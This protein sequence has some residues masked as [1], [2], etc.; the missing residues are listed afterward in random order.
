LVVFSSKV[1]REKKKSGD[2]S[3]N[4]I[5]GCG[6]P[7][8]C[9]QPAVA[10]G[11]I[12]ADLRGELSTHL[13]PQ[14]LFTQSSPVC[15]PLLQAFPFPSPLG[16]VTLHPLSQPCVFIHSSHGKWVFPPLLW[17]FLP[18]ATFTSF[19]TSGCWAC[20]AA[21]PAFSSPA[22]C[23]GFPL[24]HLQCSGR[25][26]LFATCLFCCYC[27]LFRFF[28]P[29]PLGGG[30]SVQGAMLIWPRVVCG[31]TVYRFAHLVVRVF[32]SHLGATVWR[33][34]GSPPGFSI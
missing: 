33:Q 28:F 18:T 29:F 15:E 3:E 21:V 9:C 25:P 26:A 34:R 19:P 7:A 5:C 14:A 30:R 1:G 16:E 23:E 17:S 10:G 31:S 11:I 4:G 6:L 27:L 22:C 13:A 32:P 12:Y 2:S 20:A 24:P 8:R